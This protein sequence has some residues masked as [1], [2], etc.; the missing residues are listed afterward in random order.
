MSWKQRR[1]WVLELDIVLSYGT[2]VGRRWD[3]L[4][5]Q[6]CAPCVRRDW[7]GAD[8]LIEHWALNIAPLI[9]GRLHVYLFECLSLDCEYLPGRY[10]VDLL[11]E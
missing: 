6:Q 8:Q 9:F 5:N 10:V 3:V 2:W 7:G 1:R 11:P 4:L